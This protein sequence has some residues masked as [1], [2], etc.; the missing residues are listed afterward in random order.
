MALNDAGAVTALDIA[1]IQIIVHFGAGADADC[2]YHHRILLRRISPGDSKWIILTPDHDRYVEDLD[3]L[4]WY[5][6]RRNH[7]F[8]DEYIQAGLY[9]FD[10]ID[11]QILRQQLRD[12]KEEAHLQG[13][14]SE[15]AVGAAVWRFND[16]RF[17]KF[18]LPVE[19]ELVDDPNLFTEMAG[20]A[21][22]L[23]SGVIYHAELVEPEEFDTWKLQGVKDLHDSRLLP[24]PRDAQ[25]STLAAYLKTCAEVERPLWRFEGSRV[26]REWFTG[27]ANGPANF[28]SY[29]A[30]WI[31][32]SGVAEGC[33]QAHEHRQLCECFRMSVHDDGLDIQNISSFEQLV[34]RIVQIEMAVDKNP[35][36]P[37]F[38][39]LGILVD[40][41]TTAGGAARVPKFTS[42]VTSRQ[43]EQG[44]I[45][46]QR[47]LYS[48]ELGK[49]EKGAPPRDP[50]APAK[51]PKAP[52][53]KA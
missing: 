32:M 11:P 23:V 24:G 45:W 7:A 46:K 27:V 48:E 26:A 41:T 4:E 51:K 44:D 10:P 50:L 40:G 6:I 33:A 29:H 52:K 17:N 53:P 15:A 2:P 43:K 25:P 14:D 38:T 37:D 47:R 22:V 3:D 20:H 49:E 39:G 42:W 12:A 31:R 8:P 34:R 19:Q 9:H 13:G 30:E 1:Q 36:H 5:I 35:K 21:L 28:T 18:S 16:P